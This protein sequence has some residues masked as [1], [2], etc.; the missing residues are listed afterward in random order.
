MGLHQIAAQLC[1]DLLLSNTAVGNRSIQNIVVHLVFRFLA[2]VAL[3]LIQNFHR[4]RMDCDLHE[5][6]LMFRQIQFPA[7]IANG[8]SGVV[9]KCRK[10]AGCERLYRKPARGRIDLKFQ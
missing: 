10:Q 9:S 8:N 7:V 1:T 2:I 5:R 6:F 3:H 4:A